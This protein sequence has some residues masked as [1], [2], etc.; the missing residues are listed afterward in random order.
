[1]GLNKTD[2]FCGELVSNSD[3]ATYTDYFPSNK[4]M[5][6]VKEVN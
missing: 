2:M 3:V 6:C 4:I 5:G 1:M